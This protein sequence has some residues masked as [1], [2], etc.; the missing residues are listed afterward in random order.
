MFKLLQV[1]LLSLLLTSCA[2]SGSGGDSSDSSAGNTKQISLKSNSTGIRV[3]HA[4]IDAAPVDLYS[5]GQDL[6]QT[7]QFG[8]T[9]SYIKAKA[10]LQTFFLSETQNPT[11]LLDQFDLDLSQGSRISLLFFG[12]QTSLGLHSSVLDQAKPELA[13]G[14]AAIR[15][16]HGLVG[17]LNLSAFLDTDTLAKNIA[18]GSAAEYIPVSPGIRTFW[19]QRAA[20]GLTVYSAAKEIK[21]G[22]YYTFLVAGEVDYFVNSTT[23][24][25]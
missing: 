18:F 20:D 13:P 16:V 11:G 1:A 12:N 4:A 3:L 2:G 23:Y 8:K 7:A 10:G 5:A 24:Q 22:E 14:M 21:A 25:D 9:T 19:A 6:L 17:A 15:V